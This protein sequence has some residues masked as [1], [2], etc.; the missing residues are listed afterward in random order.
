MNA[1]VDRYETVH[2]AAAQVARSAKMLVTMIVQQHSFETQEAPHGSESAKLQWMMPV[3]GKA[4]LTRTLAITPKM[5]V[6]LRTNRDVAINATLGFS[7]AHAATKDRTFIQVATGTPKKDAPEL[8]AIRDPSCEA[9]WRVKLEYR[10]GL[11][12]KLS[13]EHDSDEHKELTDFLLELATDR[14]MAQM[15]SSPMLRNE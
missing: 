3:V 5:D 1:L 10:N 12:A 11:L 14:I 6:Y 4:T 2:R 15:L 7:L 13:F 9:E 8:L